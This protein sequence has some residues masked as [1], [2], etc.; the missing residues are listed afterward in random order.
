V[1][2]D[3]GGAN[4]GSVRVEMIEDAWLK[5]VHMNQIRLQP[6]FK[7]QHLIAQSA[8]KAEI[9]GHQQVLKRKPIDRHAVDE[10]MLREGMI[11]SGSN[12]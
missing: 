11:G 5:R 8:N 12:D 3:Q 7:I 2:R 6:P 4:I 1:Y 10:I 9:V